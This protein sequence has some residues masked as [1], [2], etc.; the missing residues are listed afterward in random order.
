[1]KRLVTVLTVMMLVGNSVGT[2]SAAPDRVPFTIRNDFE[3]GEMEAWEAYPFAQDIGY[4]PFTTCYREPTHNGSRFSLG[5]VQR[6]NDIVELAE[7]FTKEIDLWTVADTRLKA[8][9]Y[10]MS[11]RKPET[12]EVSL[13]LFDGRRYFSTIKAPSANRWV[14]LDIPVRQFT[15]NGTPLKAG[16][17]VQAVTIKAS[18]PIVSNLWNYTIFLDDFA[19]NGERQR[20]FVGV[21][22]A[23][24][25]FEM[26]DFSILNRHFFSGDPLDISV[27]PESAPG[28]GALSAVSC[29]LLD[30]SGKA[31]VSG[32]PLQGSNGTWSVK[33]AYTFRDTD[34][35]GQWTVAF[36]GKTA[37]G[38]TVE[39]GFRFLMP[40]KRLTP[41]DHPRLYFDA[42]ELRKMITDP[43]GKNIL[44][45]ALAKPEYFRNLDLNQYT[46]A[47]GLTTEAATGGPYTKIVFEG[48]R[49]PMYA[50]SRTIESGAW[51]YAFTGDREAGEKAREAMLRLC[52]FKMWNLPWQEAHG[53]HIYY[54]VGYIIGPIGVGYDLLYP[55]L[56]EQ[57]KKIVRDALME[58][59]IKQFYRDMVE[60]NRMPSNLT[61]HISVIVS[62]LIIDATAIYGEDPSN[63]SL[64]P[65]VSGILAKMKRYMDRTFYPD[66]GYGEPM[67]YQD[68]AARDLVKAM[69]V[70]ERNFGV[71]YTSTTSLKDTWLYPL[72]TCTSGGKM[73]EMGDDNIQADYNFTGNTYMWLSYRMKNPWTYNFVRKSLEA[74]KGGFMGYFWQPQGV[75][76]RS[77]EELPPSRHFE[78]K[79]NM[80]MRSDWSDEA[81]VLTFKCGPNSNHYHVDQGHFLLMTNG[82]ALLTEAGEE[83]GYYAN[84]YYPCYDIQG[85]GHNTL[86][87]DNDAESQVCADFRKGVAALQSWPHIRHSFAGYAFD[88]VEGELSCVFKGKLQEYTRSMLYVKPGIIF[89]FDRVKSPA[90]HQYSWLFHAEHT[91]GKSSITATKTAVDIE[92]PKARLHMDILSPAIA[93]SQVRDSNRDESFVTL[94]TAKGTKDPNFLATLFPSAKKDGAAQAEKPVSTLLNP[95]GWTGAKAVCG[96]TVAL[97]FFRTGAPGSASAEGYTTDAERFSVTT[98]KQGALKGFFLRG[99]ALTGANGLSFQSVKPVS[100]SVNYAAAGADV[101]TDAAANTE[102]TVGLSKAPSNV[103]LNGSATGEWKYDSGSKTLK[104]TV[105]EGHAVVKVR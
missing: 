24:T 46:E 100:A 69:P 56:S 79:G 13:C 15:A 101:E 62:N 102:I 68:M 34:P 95:S 64:E 25:N 92:R 60:M 96:D 47:T 61:N 48:W 53:N 86:L 36:S 85:I 55:L 9:V 10:L 52:A 37:S 38:G 80:V 76:P 19:L 72:Y 26:F 71:D 28:K 75:T 58:K 39:W 84:L 49:Q 65:Y 54:P 104:V 43:A 45:N 66:G 3:T 23:S 20:R 91:N 81:S 74:G 40:G 98:D 42:L 59:G 33:N 14:E 94:S 11:D 30:P 50:L 57:D 82:E 88:S 18:Y 51:R 99:S 90:T 6:P 77:R 97:A 78:V 83:N 63:P 87:I 44:E 67:G 105:P 29:T 2:V 70:M 16:E 27:K 103:T 21:N 5:K 31:V 32:T 89:L 35:R 7:G 1:M 17:H 8:A 4:E 12:L 93:T 73:L 22:P 41:K